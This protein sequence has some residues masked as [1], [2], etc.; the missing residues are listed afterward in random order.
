MSGKAQTMRVAARVHLV[1][2][3]VSIGCNEANRRKDAFYRF[4]SSAILP[5]LLV[6]PH[7]QTLVC[8]L[9]QDIV[10]CFIFLCNGV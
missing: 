4:D 7:I 6:L 5:A 1:R 2:K 10:I 9:P 8:K 3:Q